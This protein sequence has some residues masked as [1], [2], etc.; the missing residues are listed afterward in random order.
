MKELLIL[1][2]AVLL[3]GCFN[4]KENAKSLQGHEINFEISKT[5]GDY[6]IKTEQNSLLVLNFFTSDCGAC[7]E[8]IPSLNALKNEYKDQIQIIGIM[9]DKLTKE[10]ALSFIN[11]YKMSYDVLNNAGLTAKLSRAVG[12]VF[13]VPA[14]YIFDKNGKKVEKFLGYVPQNTI[15]NVI[16]KHI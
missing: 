8:E 5:N 1:I 11:E 13:G 4:S 14:T 9:G 16:K 10:K 15:K 3:G 2:L 7:K 12:G 6:D